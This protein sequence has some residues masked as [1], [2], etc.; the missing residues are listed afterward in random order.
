MTRLLQT[1]RSITLLALQDIGITDRAIHLSAKCLCDNGTRSSPALEKLYI[2]F[3]KAIMDESLEPLV[4]ILE[5]NERLKALSLQRCSL[6]DSAQRRLRQVSR[7]K[8]KRM[9]NLSL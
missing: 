8:N 1:N 5:G 2:S 9:L 7:K 6:S 4:Q 3:N